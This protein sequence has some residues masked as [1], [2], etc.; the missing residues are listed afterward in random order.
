MQRVYHSA[1]T[2]YFHPPLRTKQSNKKL[3]ESADQYQNSLSPPIGYEE[4]ELGLPIKIFYEEN[5]SL[6]SNLAGD[7]HRGSYNSVLL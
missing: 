1:E 5:S 4:K 3:K 7:Y 2:N 6:E